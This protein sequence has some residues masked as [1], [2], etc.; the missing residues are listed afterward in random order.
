MNPSL[1]LFGHFMKYLIMYVALQLTDL[2]GYP[3]VVKT[4]PFAPSVLGQVG[5]DED[6]GRKVVVPS[7]GQDI[8]FINLLAR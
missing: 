5:N 3:L 4:F 7:G 6:E 2:K 1:D 8:A